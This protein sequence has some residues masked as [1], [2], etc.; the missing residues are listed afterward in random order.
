LLA[1]EGCQSIA[2]L[3]LASPLPGMPHWYSLRL[4]LGY[5]DLYGV[6]QH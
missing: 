2:P 1:A 6:G 5:F 4:Y 3:L